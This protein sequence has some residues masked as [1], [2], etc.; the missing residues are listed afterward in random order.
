MC[1]SMNGGELQWEAFSERPQQYVREVTF[2]PAV[3]YTLYG[4]LMFAVGFR[5]FAQ[6]RF[7]YDDGNRVPDGNY[8]S[9]GPTTSILLTLSPYSRFEV[10]GWKEFQQQ[11]SVP[12]REVSNISMS[13][14]V[15]F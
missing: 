4:K 10:Q 5:S 15:F 1:G 2:S 9:Y 13:A 14:R 6:N 8:L 12:T 7:R 3:R 11:T